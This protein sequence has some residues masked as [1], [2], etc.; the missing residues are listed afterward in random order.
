LEQNGG[1][2]LSALKFPGFALSLRWI[3]P[4]IGVQVTKAPKKREYSSAVTEE[5]SRGWRK[6]NGI[7]RLGSGVQ[8]QE[9]TI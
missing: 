3:P 7:W 4:K 1:L 9:K 2:P 6:G 5:E 8:G